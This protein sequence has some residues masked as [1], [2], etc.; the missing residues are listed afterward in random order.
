MRAD[1]QEPEQRH[2]STPGSYLMQS[3]IFTYAWSASALEVRVYLLSDT[4][5]FWSKG[6]FKNNPVDA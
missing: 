5:L 4:W 3:F 2:V 6:L 1:L